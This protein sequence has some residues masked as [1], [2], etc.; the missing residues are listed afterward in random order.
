MAGSRKKSTK[1]ATRVKKT[2]VE[3]KPPIGPGSVSAASDGDIRV[4]LDRFLG[5]AYDKSRE[6]AYSTRLPV[7]ALS[8]ELGIA[9]KL[10]EK[11]ANYLETQGL[12]NYDS[13]AVDL[14]V[15]GILKAEEIRRR[16]GRG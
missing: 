10:G 2:A 11:V 8:A 13:Q 9:P 15:E 3:E 4:T 14:T 6:A 12:L 1:R 7:E 5:M 16:D